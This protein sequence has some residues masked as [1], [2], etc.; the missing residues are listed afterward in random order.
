MPQDAFTLKRVSGELNDLL[1]G[2]KITKITQPDKDTLIFIIYTKK[3]TVKLEICLSA[4]ACRINLSDAEVKAPKTAL[5]FCMLLRKYLQNAE[6]TAV[7][8]I[9]DERIVFFDLTCTQEF[10]ITEMRLYCEIMGKYSNAVLCKDGT[11]VGA[12][13][14]TAIGE[15][16]KRVLFTGAKYALPEAQDK[17]SPSD[18]AGLEKLF[19]NF[20]G[21]AADFLSKNVRG[22]CYSTA[23][24][25]A[26]TFG[27]KLGVNEA[28]SYLNCETPSPCLTLENGVPTDFKVRSCAK[29]KRDFDSVLAAQSAYYDYIVRRD[30]LAEKRRKTL[31]I[32]GAAIKKSEKR[33]SAIEERIYDC[34]DMETTKLKGELITAN[35][36][37]ISRGDDSVLADNYYDGSRLKI[38]LDRSLS[39]AD[40]AQ[41]YY[42]RYAKLK[43]TLEI[44]TEQKLEA[45]ARLDYLKSIETHAK[46]AEKCEDFVEI[47]EELRLSGLIKPDGKSKKQP[48]LPP[49]R[50]YLI[51][52]F[53]V[54]SGRN[55]MQNDRLLKALAPDDIWLHTKGYHSSHVGIV[56]AG[57]QPPDGVLEAAAQICAY[58]SEGKGSD[59]VPVDYTLR[60]FVKKP[61]G[62]PSGFVTYT[63][64]KTALVEAIL[65]FD[66]VKQ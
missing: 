49:L 32:V 15:S 40:N 45:E 43:R 13:K 60:K 39:P 65:N 44:N 16:T 34:R 14:T 18:R 57:K 31:A 64:Q 29:E 36:Y 47:E 33:L 21:D 38:A 5:S 28:Y 7:R 56:C 50:T 17:V 54:L 6:I 66:E 9:P 27:D 24:D 2:G 4:R 51:D 46:S 22:V 25:I 52:G 30:V 41:K 37:R 48:T 19:E 23:L 35:I 58:F 42:K 62:A 26:L 12:L 20:A 1:V 59:K 63:N 3:T 53:T 10:E 8:Q 61:S 11:I 55:N